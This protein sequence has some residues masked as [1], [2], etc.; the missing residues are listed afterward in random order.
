[1]KI[2]NVA[3][4]N[5]PL[6][7]W[8]LHDE[9]D[10]V[11]K[12]NYISATGLMK[13]VKQTILASR[14]PPAEQQ[15]DVQDLIARSLGHAIHDSIEKAWVKGHRRALK[16]LGYPDDVITRV[17]VNPTDEELSLVEDP[18]PV[19]LEQ[20]EFRNVVVNGVTYII[21]GKYDMLAEGI[22]HDHKS[23]SVWSFVK[24]SKDEDYALQP[25]IY[26]WLNPKKAYADFAKINFIFTDWSKMMLRTEG[27]PQHRVQEKVFPLLSLQETEAW[28]KDRI[29]QFQRYKDSP[30]HEIPECTSKE[31]WMSD[32]SYKY[33][34]DPTKTSG[35]STKNFD[36][37]SE[38]Q[39]FMASKGGKGVVITVP[40]EAKACGYCP[41]FDNCQQKDRYL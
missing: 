29:S 31:L 5:L 32:P 22:V 19:Y 34:A 20:R 36:N 14:I 1:M 12:P 18:I 28:I 13:S 8:L 38:A 7:V 23:T 39:G 9:Y 27:Y 30:E 3:G 10:Y 17:M 6:A 37:K 11:D 41:A 40:G 24:G 26:R 25:S 33:Y 2:T 35:R 15:M 16:L 4:I 21:G